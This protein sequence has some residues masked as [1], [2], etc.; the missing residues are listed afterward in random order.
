MRPFEEEYY[1]CREGE[2]VFGNLIDGLMSMLPSF[3]YKE[4]IWI[5]NEEELC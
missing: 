1:I 4:R 3:L 2:K 5:A